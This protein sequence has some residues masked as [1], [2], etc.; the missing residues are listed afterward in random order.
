MTIIKS[1][2]WNDVTR[3]KNDCLWDK[4]RLENSQYLS[5][6]IIIINYNEITKLG[7]L[8]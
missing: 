2:P 4:S 6:L 3:E 1:T 5:G 8:E 7:E